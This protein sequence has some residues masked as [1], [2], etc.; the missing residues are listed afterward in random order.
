MAS[1]PKLVRSNRLCVLVLW[2]PRLSPPPL[3]ETQRLSAAQVEVAQ[4]QV[5]ENHLLQRLYGVGFEELQVPNPEMRLFL[6]L[7]RE[8][9]LLELERITT[10]VGWRPRPIRRV[11]RALRH[12]LM[13]VGVWRHDP[14]FP[15]LVG[16]AR[17]I[18]DGVINATV[19]DVVIHPAYQ[20]A[21]LG[22][23]LMAFVVGRLRAMGVEHVTLFADPGVIRFYQNQGWE[24]EPDNQRC[25]FWYAS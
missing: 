17:C 16:F 14:F 10:A 3:G 13:V 2:R 5:D 19:W 18:G 4:G 8:V 12:S 1:G 23:G 22:H 20:G 15:R 24:V 25:C 7:E 9:D 21:G 6:S 11:R